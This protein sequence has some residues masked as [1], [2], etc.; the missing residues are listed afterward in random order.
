MKCHLCHRR[1]RQAA[2]WLSGKP[3]G[4]VCARKTALVLPKAKPVAEVAKKGRK[5]R[6]M[7]DLLTLEMFGEV[8]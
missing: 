1:L 6:A 4:P 2:Y 5:T 8:A 7:R 3:I